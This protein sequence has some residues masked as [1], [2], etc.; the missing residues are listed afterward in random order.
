MPAAFIALS[1]RPHAPHAAV[2]CAL[3]KR[4]SPSRCPVPAALETFGFP[5]VPSLAVRGPQDRHSQ[6]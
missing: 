4:G 5:A 6:S 2:A 1:P 3:V